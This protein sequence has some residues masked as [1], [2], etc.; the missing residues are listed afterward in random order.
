MLRAIQCKTNVSLWLVKEVESQK[1]L[2][3][4]GVYVDDL[5]LWVDKSELEGAIH[6][7]TFMHQATYIQELAKRYGNPRA[8]A[9]LPDFK[10]GDPP[11]E[12]PNSSTIQMAQRVVVDRWQGEARH[13]VRGERLCKL[14]SGYPGYVQQNGLQI[15]RC[16]H[17]P[18]TGLSAM[19]RW[20]T[21]V[22][23]W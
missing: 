7:T 19:A 6:G 9:M 3:S 2:G 5:M 13:L 21:L 15:I 23:L 11:E 4:L 17:I 8:S 10:K 18:S 1:T 20:S 22:S 16:R 14:V 12:E